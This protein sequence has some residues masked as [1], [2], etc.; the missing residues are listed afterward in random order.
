MRSGWNNSKAFELAENGTVGGA[1][2]DAEN[3]GDPGRVGLA[4]VVEN[5]LPNWQ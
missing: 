5:G 1:G 2:A 4:Q 3:L